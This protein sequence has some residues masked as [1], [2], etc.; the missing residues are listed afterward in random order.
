MARGNLQN[1][2]DERIDPALRR[3]LGFLGT[4]TLKRDFTLEVYIGRLVTLMTHEPYDYQAVARAINWASFREKNGETMRISMQDF[5]A[6]IMDGN[7]GEDALSTA[8]NFLREVWM[9]GD[10]IP[11]RDLSAMGQNKKIP[12]DILWQ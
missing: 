2:T 6:G 3:R 1:I 5:R 10:R 7:L 4:I 8:K 9:F 12:A 11:G